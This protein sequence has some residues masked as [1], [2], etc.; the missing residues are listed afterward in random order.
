MGEETTDNE[1]Y[2]VVWENKD[3]SLEHTFV[4][5]RFDESIFQYMFRV[6]GIDSQKVCQI[7][8]RIYTK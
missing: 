8:K 3:E 4:W 2:V 7:Y 5:L 6:H 1:F